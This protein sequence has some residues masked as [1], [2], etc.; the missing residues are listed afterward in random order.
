MLQE[1]GR[2][3]DFQVVTRDTFNYAGGRV[4]SSWIRDALANGEL[5]LAARLLGR[6]YAMSGRV[7]HGKQLGRTIGYPTA[8]ILPHR[9]ACPLSGIYVVTLAGISHQ[10]LPGVAS[11]GTRPTVNGKDVILE[12]HLFDFQQDIYGRLVEVEFREKLRDE[13]RFDSVEEMTVQIDTDAAQAREYFI[14]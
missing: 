5:D 1:L 14:H 13:L 9:N 3:H 12:V 2:K 8:N 11:V 10:P 4:S 6:P 7:R